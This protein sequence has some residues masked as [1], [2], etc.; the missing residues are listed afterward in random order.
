VRLENFEI[1]TSI[2]LQF[3]GKRWDLHNAAHFRG[4]Q[5]LPSDNAA[6]MKWSSTNSPSL[7]GRNGVNLLFKGLQFLQISARDSDLPLT[8]DTCVADILKVDPSVQHSD[9][10]VRA[11]SDFSDQFRLVFCFQSAR[12]I[13]IGSDAVRLILVNDGDFEDRDLT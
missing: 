13:E 7:P 8:E 11:I 4:L 9:P 3:E 12:V 2:E 10:H 5:L 6:I 1:P